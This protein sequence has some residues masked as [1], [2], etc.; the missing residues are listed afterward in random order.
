M[1]WVFYCI[2]KYFLAHRIR[3]HLSDNV[4]LILLMVHVM[5]F[6][7]LLPAIS[8][9]NGLYSILVLLLD[10]ET[11]KSACKQRSAF[12]II[13]GWQVVISICILHHVGMYEYALALVYY[14]K[15]IL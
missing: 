9:Y 1:N 10:T 12:S 14:H 5:S 6:Q 11:H 15:D 2:F 13:I 8:I 4:Q 3:I 7:P